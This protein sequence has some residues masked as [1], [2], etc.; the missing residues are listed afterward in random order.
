MK[1][2]LVVYYENAKTRGT[3]P[4]SVRRIRSRRDQVYHSV[5]KQQINPRAVI[6]RFLIPTRTERLIYTTCALRPFNEIYALFYGL[7]K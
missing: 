6:I 1:N 3:Q 2:I 4:P 7:K 5:R